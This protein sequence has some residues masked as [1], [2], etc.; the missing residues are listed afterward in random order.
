MRQFLQNYPY[1]LT[2]SCTTVFREVS[3]LPRVPVHTLVFDLFSFCQRLP[4]NTFMISVE[5]SPHLSLVNS[6]SAIWAQIGGTLDLWNLSNLIFQVQPHTSKLLTHIWIFPPQWSTIVLFFKMA[7]HSIL[8]FTP[9]I[10]WP[11]RRTHIICRYSFQRRSS[12]IFTTGLNVLD[13]L[14]FSTPST[15]GYDNGNWWYLRNL[16]FDRWML[17]R[18]T[19]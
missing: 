5:V 19:W 1:T 9:N 2:F 8:I 3:L 6:R 16:P 14:I 17:G 18:Y 7:I 12:E 15:S 13:V 10:Y 11:T 4:I